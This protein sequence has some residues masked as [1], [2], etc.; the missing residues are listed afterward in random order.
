M[1]ITAMKSFGSIYFRQRNY[2]QLPRAVTELGTCLA[3]VKVENLAMSVS[4]ST[5]TAR[6]R[7]SGEMVVCD[8]VPVIVVTGKKISAGVLSE[9]HPEKPNPGQQ[10]QPFKRHRKSGRVCNSLRGCLRR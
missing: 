1:I 2:L 7:H 4:I 10:N 3:Q 6:G 5:Q 9:Q 8:E